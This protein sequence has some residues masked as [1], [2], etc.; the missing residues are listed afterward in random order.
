MRSAKLPLNSSVKVLTSESKDKRRRFKNEIAFLSRNQHAHIV[1]VTDHGVAAAGSVRGPF[2]VMERYTGSLRDE[3]NSKLSSDR[4]MPLFSQII[5]GVEA[6][7]F[8]EVTHRDLKPENVLIR[9][10]GNIAAVADFGVASF[11]ADQLLTLVK[12]APTTRLANFQYAAPEQRVAGRTVGVTADIYALGL[13]L[14]ELF[15]GSAPHGTDYQLISSA[16]ADYAFLDP[17]VAVMIRQDPAERPQSIAEVKTLIQR[18][19]AEAVS[20]QRLRE[21]DKVVVPIGEVSDPLAH[22]PPKLIGAEYD[23]G[24]LRL[25]LDRP[26]NE[27]WVRALHNMGNYSAPMEAPPEA[28]RFN[29]AEVVV[30]VPDHAAQRAIDHFK[31]WL[32]RASDVLKYT[33]EQEARRQEE[34][35]RNQLKRDRDAEQRRLE[36]N[37]SLRL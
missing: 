32:P 29:R 28:F 37:R 16:S 17:I 7:H 21:L 30:N 33:L 6:A 14:N 27:N 31:Q 10:S 26:V 22:Q 19:R 34:E 11:T 18:H 20:L 5:D 15:T 24:T 12:T 3:L 8:Q 25:K 35:R 13:M 4:V 1:T 9:N 2:Y 23:A 36:V